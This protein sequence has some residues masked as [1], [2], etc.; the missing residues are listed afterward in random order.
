MKSKELAETI[1]KR[2]NERVQP[3][4]KN[5]KQGL[6]T[7]TP[8]PKAEKAKLEEGLKWLITFINKEITIFEGVWALASEEAWRNFDKFTEDDPNLNLE[9]VGLRNDAVSALLAKWKKR[10]GILKRTKAI[11]NV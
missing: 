5:A 8:S 7:V 6:F 2:F 10:P 4:M 1:V 11:Q 9:E 3:V